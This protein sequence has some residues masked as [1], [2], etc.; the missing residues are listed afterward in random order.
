MLSNA[1]NPPKSTVELSYMCPRGPLVHQQWHSPSSWNKY[2]DFY[3]DGYTILISDKINNMDHT[4]VSGIERT[5][6]EF[7]CEKGMS[8]FA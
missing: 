4:R 2:R 5:W 6:K 8:Y 3:Y 7:T 1:T